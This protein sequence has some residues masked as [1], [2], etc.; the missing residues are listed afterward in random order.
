M[1]S[2]NFRVTRDKIKMTFPFQCWVI[3][4]EYPSEITWILVCFLFNI[5]QQYGTPTLGPPTDPPHLFSDNRKCCEC[6]QFATTILRHWAPSV[7]YVAHPVIV[8][9]HRSEIYGH[10]L[11]YLSGVLGVH[12]KQNNPHLFWHVQGSM[13]YIFHGTTY[14]S[15]E[16]P[17]P[18]IFMSNHIAY[19]P[20]GYH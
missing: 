8:Y 1:G 10:L 20:S 3:M 19:C 12:L 6:V 14:F 13:H 4:F 5:S 11:G 7:S 18:T 16:M 15:S 2:Y 17:F 9:V